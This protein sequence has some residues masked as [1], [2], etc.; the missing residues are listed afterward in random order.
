MGRGGWIT[1]AR[2]F[3]LNIDAPLIVGRPD[4]LGRMA[5][6]HLNVLVSQYPN[7]LIHFMSDLGTSPGP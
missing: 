5:G 3:Q 6:D 2:C 1:E 4:K 7:A